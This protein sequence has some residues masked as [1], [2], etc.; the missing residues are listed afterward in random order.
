MTLDNVEPPA[1][2]A[3]LTSAQAAQRLAQF[4][5]NQLKPRRQNL[6]L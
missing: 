4:G 5:T 2:S 3:G 1:A 6:L